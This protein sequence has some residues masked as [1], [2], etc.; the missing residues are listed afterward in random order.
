MKKLLHLFMVFSVLFSIV[1]P[2]DFK[3]KALSCSDP[4]TF[5]YRVSVVKSDGSTVDISCHTDYNE[6]RTAMLS[7]SADATK[8]SVIYNNVGLI[9]NAKYAVVRFK[10]G[11]SNALLYPTNVSS[12][13]YTSIHTSY[14]SD[15][16]FIDYDPGSNRVKVK[17]SGYAGWTS[18]ANVER[19]IPVSSINSSQVQIVASSLRV[20]NTTSV[21]SLENVIGYVY[22]GDLMTYYEKTTAEG[23]TWYRISYNCRTGWIANDG[24]NLTEYNGIGLKTYYTASSRTLKHYYAYQSSS[25]VVQGVISL[26]PAPSYIL[27]SQNYFSFDG[28]YFYSDI[29]KMLD[30]Y[31]ND[32]VVNAIN[33]N[34]PHYVYYMYL[35]A[36]SKTRY[37]ANDF[38]LIITNKGYTRGKLDGV[39]YV[40]V[41]NGVYSFTSADRSNMSV[42]YNQGQNF[43]DAANTYGVN[44]LM[45]FSTAI[46]ES[47]TGT[48]LLAF[49]KNNIFSWNAAD[50]CPISCATDFTTVKDAIFSYAKVKG[51]YSSNY[52]NPLGS[53]YYGSHYGNKGS[54]NNISYATDPY[55][56]EKQ[57]A[58]SFNN[59]GKYGGQD[60]LSNTIGIT[61]GLDVP[62]YKDASLTSSVLYV[63]KNKNKSVLN[64][65]AIVFDQITTI[66][67]GKSIGWYKVHTDVSLDSSRNIADVDYNFNQSYGYVKASDLYVLNTQPTITANDITITQGD[68]VNLLNG[69]SASD[70]EDGD[71]TSQLNYS[72]TYDVDKPATYPITYTVADHSGFYKNK[73]IN[74]VVNPSEYAYISA[75]DRE[76]SQYVAFEPKV[77][78]TANDYRDGDITDSITVTSNNVNVNQKGTYS[79]TYSVTNSLGKITTKTITVTVVANASPV[80]DVSNK[81]IKINDTFNPLSGVAATDKEDGTL[82]S[83]IEIVSN[84]V[85]PA[86][87]GTYQVQ[88]K[89][90]DAAG[91]ISTK[92]ISVVVED[93]TYVNKTGQFYFEKMSWNET[94][95][96][97]DVSGY[98][99]I[100]GINNTASSN[101]LY[102]IIFRN[103]ITGTDTVLGLQRWLNG[104]PSR[105]YSDGIY[106]YSETWF[107]GSLDLSS[108]PAGEY[109]L[110]VRARNGNDQATN[111]FR[112]VL[113]KEMTRKIQTSTGRGYLFRNN[114]YNNN[115]PIEVFIT[116]NGLIA[117]GIPVHSSNMFNSYKTMNLNNN[118]LNIIGTSFNVGGDYSS[119][120]TVTRQLIL[121]NQITRDRI[122]YN[123]GSIV[124]SEIPLNVSD[125]KSKVRGWFDTTG[126]VDLANVP[127]GKYTIYIRTKTGTIDDYGE[128][129]D[130]F[131]KPTNSLVATINGKTYSVTLNR[132]L[133]FRMELNVQ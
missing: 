83:S 35:P 67:D 99:A 31:R 108:I 49:Y 64:V 7:Y 44:A 25:S 66:E 22:N 34:T 90:T 98:L 94:T 93:R 97:L 111:L 40:Q 29:T 126:K 14:G 106:N 124:G 104:H 75:S 119:G 109:T 132:N 8:V 15:A 38:N 127:V 11:I 80:I 122:T 56:G 26:G 18:M 82:T 105:S 47:S 72:G 131:L 84:N 113:G 115:Y 58:I 121:E 20:R 24:T 51:S 133:R 91:N 46:N 129:N 60:Y 54:G 55:W 74:L 62:V 42:M 123:I 81:V 107:T 110:Y 3:A 33:V 86:V 50:S 23:Y 19:I 61:R 102:D 17:I 89:V 112:N 5:T 52:S 10:P 4:A 65:P 88:Y 57:A 59:D 9:I 73:T 96:R 32:V 6:A 92:E 117:T 120:A 77:D 78:V 2:Y 95:N 13:S 45:M 41:V 28:N 103:N 37:N 85:N 39:N 70:K 53:Y 118:S 36:H 63:I 130:I 100:T 128:L 12:T 114:N 30:D 87:L 68:S 116:D 43:I 16:A 71:I 21:A 101:L 48:S 79:V 1:T 69:V 125:G 27:D 76:V